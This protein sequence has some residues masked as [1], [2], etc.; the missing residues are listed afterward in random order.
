MRQFLANSLF[1]IAVRARKSP[2][3]ETSANTRL[4]FSI[5]VRARKSPWI[6]TCLLRRPPFSV[7]V[8]A[9]KSPWIE[10]VERE[11]AFNLEESGLVRARGLKLRTTSRASR[12]TLSGLV[13]ARGLKHRDCKCLSFPARGLKQIIDLKIGLLSVRARKSPWIETYPCVL[14]NE[15]LPSGL[16]RARGL[17]LLIVPSEFQDFTSGLVSARGLKLI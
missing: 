3:I 10:T 17:K 8:R 12:C 15:K 6:E 7:L 4:P 16:V 2:W 5:H 14:N 13:R 9:R 11:E 1:E